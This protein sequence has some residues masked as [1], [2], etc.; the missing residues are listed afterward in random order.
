MHFLLGVPLLLL[1]ALAVMWVVGSL[2]SS[3]RAEIESFA[4]Q[5][6]SRLW[7]SMMINVVSIGLIF[8]EL[9][10]ARNAFGVVVLVFWIVPNAR[11]AYAALMHANEVLQSRCAPWLGFFFTRGL[12]MS[13]R[14]SPDL[15]ARWKT[16]VAVWLM[17]FLLSLG[18]GAYDL[19]V[20]S[21]VGNEGQA[22][23]VAPAALEQAAALPLPVEEPALV[24]T[25]LPKGTSLRTGPGRQYKRLRVLSEASRFIVLDESVPGW[26]K[27]RDGDSVAWVRRTTAR[28]SRSSGRKAASKA[29]AVPGDSHEETPQVESR[30]SG[31]GGPAVETA[32]NGVEDIGG[33]LETDSLMKLKVEAKQLTAEDLGLE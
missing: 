10:R 18:Y 26:I 7:T 14:D 16:A 6:M 23:V 31:G 2:T 5:S 3:A 19:G 24:G 8:A 33:D 1:T 17:S 28:E 12:A 20:R 25:A 4:R 21:R 13:I 30:G 11:S 29:K 15:Y 32:T 27:I 9:H 22:D